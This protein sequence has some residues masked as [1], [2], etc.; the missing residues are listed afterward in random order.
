MEEG[1]LEQQEPFQDSAQ[2]DHNS[3]TINNDSSAGDRDAEEVEA[4]VDKMS[5]VTREY[6]GDDERQSIMSAETMLSASMSG[7]LLARSSV[8]SDP[9]HKR[10]AAMGPRQSSESSTSSVD[11]A[12]AS[13]PVSPMPR[14]K[15]RNLPHAKILENRQRLN[16]IKSSRSQD[17]SS[18]VD[19]PAAQ[20]SSSTLTVSPTTA[21]TASSSKTLKKT[22]NGALMF[23]AGG[24]GK[25]DPVSSVSLPSSFDDF[26]QP[27][28]EP[29]SS[30]YRV[31]IHHTDELQNPF[32]SNSE[33]LESIDTEG[34]GDRQPLTND[35]INL[36]VRLENENKAI[37]SAHH[38]T[39]TSLSA[40][41]AS[42]PPIITTTRLLGSRAHYLNDVFASI[43]S[44]PSKEISESPVQTTLQDSEP[45]LSPVSGPISGALSASME[46][47]VDHQEADWDFWGKLLTDLESIVRKQNKLLVKKTHSGLPKAVRGT[48]W[49][50]FS[51]L[52]P[53]SFLRFTSHSNTSNIS[54][55][56]STSLTSATNNSLSHEKFAPPETFRNSSLEDAYV[57]LLKLSSP[58]EKMIIRDLARTF[59]KHEFFKHADG[60]G[61]ESLFN[62]MKAYSLYDPEVGYCQGL[63]FIV[64]AL[65]L[66]MPDE[67]AFSCL[68]H[69]MHTYEF[70]GCFTPR[71]ELLQLRLYQFDRILQELMPRV[72]DHLLQEG[73]RSTMYASQWFLTIFSYRFPLEVVFRIMDIIFATGVVSG[74]SGSE[75]GVMDAMIE[76]MSEGVAA[77]SG[78]A[79]FKAHDVGMDVAIV[80][81]R[82]ALALLKKNEEM[83]LALD[84]EPLLEFLKHGL[85]QI[86]TGF[87]S[88]PSA[89]K[90][91]TGDVQMETLYENPVGNKS[92]SAIRHTHVPAYSINEIVKDAMSSQ[93]KSITKKKLNQ[94][95]KEYEEELKKTD[96]EYLAEKSLEAQNQR[97]ADDLKRSE[98]LLADLNRDHCE[99]AG[100]LISVRIELTKEKDVQE[101]L[102]RQISDLKTIL[103][104][105]ISKYDKNE[106]Q[107][108]IEHNVTT[109]NSDQPLPAAAPIPASESERTPTVQEQVQILTRQNIQ[110]IQELDYWRAKHDDLSRN[111]QQ[112]PP[113]TNNVHTAASL[114]RK[115]FIRT[116]GGSNNQPEK[117]EANTRD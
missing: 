77:V 71:M 90:Q 53:H 60:L 34:K 14:F 67:Q 114:A 84:F 106:L 41:V 10:N 8:D 65:L 95:R 4:E 94:L 107:K 38:E 66:H 40:P 37:K 19:S 22:K 83:I 33:S 70:R 68:V 47:G 58:Y 43:S 35:E 55:N 116:S 44:S 79:Q 97:L 52:H 73:I 18:S 87:P 45:A 15:H 54:N 86:Y 113:I 32:P 112:G 61:Q 31:S 11:M 57:E 109:E 26:Q 46:D 7:P 82:F 2:V 111:R 9:G 76:R 30:A 39:L 49:Y 56:A 80:L 85:F 6:E 98:R 25:A 105:D 5:I 59:P 1:P 16:A 101:A 50:N 36:L 28:E 88:Q 23:T 78:A 48:I 93:W 96:P 29:L 91:E 69:L 13:D 99:L 21:P 20:S 74:V 12:T 103:Q 72:N 42:K 102:R 27:A 17:S 92:P 62:V 100:Q 110:L 51:R 63:S 89:E 117:V 108:L 24:G 75:G 3:D 81:F 104:Q 115:L 64:G